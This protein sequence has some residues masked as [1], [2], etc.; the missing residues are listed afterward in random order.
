[1]IKQEL[2]QKFDLKNAS[3][4]KKASFFAMFV[5]VLF[6][7]ILTISFACI[8]IENKP[9]FKEIKISFA[10]NPVVQKQEKESVKAEEK[11]S[12]NQEVKKEL[13]KKETVQPKKTE[14]PKKSQKTETSKPK[15][16]QNQNT[17]KPKVSETKTLPPKPAVSKPKTQNS[18]ESVKNPPKKEY[19]YKKS[20]EELMEEQL[21]SAK[22]TEW[23]ENAFSESV[24][25]SSKTETKTTQNKILSSNQA[26]SGTAGTFSENQKA[27]ISSSAQKETQKSVSSS[28]ANALKQIAESTF[29]SSVSENVTTTQ[30]ISAEKNVNGQMTVKLNNGE[31]RIL[32]EPK[33]PVIIISEQAA[34]TLDSSR[35]VIIQFKILSDGSVPR[36][37]IT[38]TPSSS[39]TQIIKDEVESQI[40]KWIFA[41]AQ[42]DGYAKFEYS[43]IRK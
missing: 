24:T 38:F 8:K 26:L 18:S 28:T 15:T 17:Q 41:K 33:K 16:P 14:L 27:E 20:L 13:P 3:L 1:M 4:Q 29:S 5:T 10:P 6:W 35:T 39:L 21:T 19:V 12:S 36:G 23:N 25:T 31:A 43:I 11:K 34:K 9:K 37:G 2:R 42:T 22:K 7:I 30:K 32:L 40:S